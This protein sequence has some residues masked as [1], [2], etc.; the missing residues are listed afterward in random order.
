M[1][2]KSPV[3]I[4]ALTEVFDGTVPS[5]ILF[6]FHWDPYLKTDGTSLPILVKNFDDDKNWAIVDSRIL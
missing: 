3:V 5:K 4:I 6:P 2:D 1:H